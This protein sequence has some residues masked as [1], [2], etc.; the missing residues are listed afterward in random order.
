MRGGDGDDNLYGHDG[1]DGHDE[2]H[3]DDGNDHL[4]GGNGADSLYGG[5]G[6]DY[7]H[8]GAWADRLDGGEGD[9]TAAYSG[10]DAGVTVNLTSSRLQ[11]GG[12]AEG[13]TLT[14]I[15]HLRGSSH[16]DHLIGDGRHNR[17]RGEEGD[18]TLEGGQGDDHL[19]GGAG[20]D[21]LKG[22][23]GY[24]DWAQYWGSEGGVTVNLATGMGQ[25]GDAEGDT[26]TGIER[27]H[28]SDHAD[29]LTGDDRDN[30]F[31]GGAG[32]DTLDG[33]EGDDN[34]GYWESNVGVTVNLATGT[35]R[36]GHAEGDTL[37]GIES[38][39]G[40]DHADH[41]TGDDGDNYLAGNA[42]ADTLDGGEGWDFTGY[43]GSDTG[44]TVNLATGTGQ[45]GYAE[46]DTLTGI[47]SLHGSD[48]A[49]HLTG[50]DG[51]NRLH[52]NGGDDTLDGGA[53]NDWLDGR[54]G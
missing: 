18:D 3:G 54:G 19:H 26:L 24:D 35:G 30:G 13:D 2:L 22:G 48:H 4:E 36:G 42:G 44:V 1:H 23:G 17:L 14:G 46:G 53:G 52:G 39:G 9:D 7:L 47:E 38:I 32:A 28:G 8:G 29:H 15:E 11:R 50:D 41:L 16:A 34:A 37:T 25:G 10:S 6:N 51:D 43:W 12:D 27:I 31:H 21:R 40:S 5:A 45:G 49:D 33:G 20:S